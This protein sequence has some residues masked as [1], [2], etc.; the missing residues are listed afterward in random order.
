[1]APSPETLS[2]SIAKPAALALT[3]VLLAACSST[4]MAY[5]YADWGIVWWV[6]DYVSLNDAQ[7]QALNSDIEAF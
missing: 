1:M 2:G 6:E 3:M 7:K 4:K 5:R